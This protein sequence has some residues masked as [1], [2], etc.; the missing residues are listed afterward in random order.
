MTGILQKVTAENLQKVYGSVRG[1]SSAGMTH[2]RVKKMEPTVKVA[3]FLFS[4]ERRIT[5]VEL[6]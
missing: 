2:K 4:E 6:S 5:T 3:P 1:V